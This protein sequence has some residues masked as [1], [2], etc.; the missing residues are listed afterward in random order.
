MTKTKNAPEKET[1]VPENLKLYAQCAKTPPE[2]RKPIEAGRLKG[3]TDINPMYRIQKLTEMFGPC[4]IGWVTRNV[5]YEQ[6]SSPDTQEVAVVCTLELLYREQE[7][8]EWAEPLF[9]VGGSKLLS[10]ERGG[11]YLNDEAYKMAYTDALSVACKSIGM[12]SD[13]YYAKDKTKYSLEE[14]LNNDPEFSKADLISKEIKR[15]AKLTGNPK[16]FMEARADLIAKGQL[17]DRRSDDMTVQELK[18]VFAVIE[19][20]LGLSQKEE[21]EEADPFLQET[22]NNS[23]ADLQKQE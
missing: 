23:K 10:L 4:G 19:K 17:L 12:C 13:I 18:K 2:A 9:G 3:F 7:S 5:K 14:S 15:V 16:A 8:G 11:L 22:K 20:S 1:Q 6:I 21:T